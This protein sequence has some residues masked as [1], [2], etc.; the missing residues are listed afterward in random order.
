MNG[1]RENTFL[2]SKNTSKRISAEVEVEEGTTGV[3]LTQGGR[4]GGWSLYMKDGRPI[5]TYNFLGLERFTVAADDA[6][7][8]GPAPT[9]PT[10]ASSTRA[11]TGD[12]R[13]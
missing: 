9:T 4:F 11:L 5:Y 10:S 2:N 6:I 12:L 8:P 13:A 3:I 7:P 1:I